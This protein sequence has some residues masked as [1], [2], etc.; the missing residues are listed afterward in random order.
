M[1]RTCF[2]AYMVA[3]LSLMFSTLASGMALASGMDCTTY[4]DSP[5]VDCTDCSNCGGLFGDSCDYYI[6]GDG[7]SGFEYEYLGRFG[8][9][10]C[11]HEH[12]PL[13]FPGT[14]GEKQQIQQQ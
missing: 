3:G 2:R 7:A 6:Y 4:C 11:H 9:G 13:P 5:G 12:D 10:D 1:R 8:S 14:P